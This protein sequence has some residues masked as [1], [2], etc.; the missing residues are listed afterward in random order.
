MKDIVFG[1]LGAL[2]LTG[3]AVTGRLLMGHLAWSWARA[4][5]QHFWSRCLP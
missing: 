3:Y 4:I 5:I 2:W 1:V